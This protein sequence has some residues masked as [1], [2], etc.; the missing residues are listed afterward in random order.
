MNGLPLSA[1]DAI[2]AALKQDWKQAVSINL[3]LL[4]QNKDDI[5]ALNRIGFAYLHLG[6][7][8]DAKNFFEK[9]IAL[10][11]YNSIAQRNL[12]KLKNKGQ[13]ETNG[14]LVSPMM[15]LEE[16]GKTKVI[17]CVNLAPATTLASVR[18]GQEVKMKPKKHTIEIRDDNNIYLAALP[19]DVSFKLNK[20]LI[21]G[22]EYSIIVRSVEKNALSVF[23]RELSRGTLFA[24]QPSFTPYSAYVAQARMNET[25][26]KPDTTAT[27]EEQPEEEN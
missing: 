17:A 7:L 11:Q 25:E 9:V 20:F 18:C 5:D 1:D 19:D 15:F 26:E 27:G 14:I 4:E 13:T 10:D 24:D 12:Q 23:I 3:Q 22:N 21:G 6:K 16:P 2:S 8:K